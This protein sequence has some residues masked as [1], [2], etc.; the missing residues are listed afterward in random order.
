VT[1][2]PAELREKIEAALAEVC[3]AEESLERAL[4]ELD[5]AQRADK[6]VVTDVVRSAFTR[7]RTAREALASLH[8]LVD[9]G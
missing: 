9:K 2:S 7:L 6:V 5:T 4:R 8:E 3:A 1:P